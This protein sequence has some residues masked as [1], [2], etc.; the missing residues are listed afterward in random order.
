MKD[1][2]VL[3]YQNFNSHHL[4]TIPFH[5]HFPISLCF[6]NKNLNCMKFF[7]LILIMHSHFPV[8]SPPQIIK[9]PPTDE[10]LYQVPQVGETDKPFVIE[11]EAEGEP[12]PM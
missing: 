1:L 10:M 4:W 2:K 8:H 5:Y 12:A 6:S 3:S 11:C 7:Y 9:Q